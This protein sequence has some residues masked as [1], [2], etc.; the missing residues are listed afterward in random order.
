MHYTNTI[1][2]SIR[3]FIQKKFVHTV[4]RTQFIEKCINYIESEM[5][6]KYNPTKIKIQKRSYAFNVFINHFLI[7]CRKN[8]WVCGVCFLAIYLRSPN[9]GKVKSAMVPFDIEMFKK[10]KL[11]KIVQNEFVC[12]GQVCL[13]SF[14][15]VLLL[16]LFFFVNVHS[17][18][19]RKN[20]RSWPHRLYYHWNAKIFS[21][22]CVCIVWFF[23]L[24]MYWMV[25]WSVYPWS[26]S[27]SVTKRN[28]SKK[29][30]KSTEQ[31]KQQQQHSYYIY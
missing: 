10:K 8:R 11:N 18:H 1:Y 26:W 12:A 29:K 14:S 6:Q 5:R 4:R 16:L 27:R 22:W 17:S 19:L 28:K 23:F 20:T 24:N 30:K 2:I 25:G 15:C 9:H 3:S 21:Y 7:E 13:W 31:K